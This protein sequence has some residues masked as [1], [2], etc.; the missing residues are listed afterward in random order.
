[1]I[2]LG[3]DPFQFAAGYD[4]PSAFA[5]ARKNTPIPPIGAL[6]KVIETRRFFHIHDVR[7]SPG[8]LARA[9]HTVEIAELAGARTL[10]IV[11]MLKENEL[12]G[13]ITIY[14]QEVKPFTDKQIALVENFT[15]QAVIAIENTQLL[16]EL[17]RR[18]ADLGENPCSSSRDRRRTQ[19]HEPLLRGP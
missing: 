18:T 13:I 15:K 14:R 1:M 8:Y 7:S 5:A 3:R 2:V 11:P 10:V 6:A 4:V 12:I 16:N 19:D 17:R 9:P